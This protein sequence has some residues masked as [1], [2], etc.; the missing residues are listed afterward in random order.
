M[1]N[2]TLTSLVT[3]PGLDGD[4]NDDG[5]VD[6]ADYVVWRKSGGTPQNY[7]IWRTNFGRSSGAVAGSAVAGAVPEPAGVLL[8][9]FGL[10]ATCFGRRRKRS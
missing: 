9:L 3:A 5:R 7:S 8:V 4:F 6:A 1:P 2:Y 10:A